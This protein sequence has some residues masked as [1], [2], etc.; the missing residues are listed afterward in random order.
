MMRA[1]TTTPLLLVAVLGCFLALVG[2]TPGLR[3]TTA[4]AR[5][6]YHTGLTDEDLRT[7]NQS[8]FAMMLGEVRAT[9]SDL[10]FLKMTRYAHAGI[11]Y[12]P[13][14]RLDALEEKQQYSGCAAG[15]PTAIRAAADDFRGF[16]GNMEREVKPYRNASKSHQH[17]D[18]AELLPWF[19]LMTLANPH[20]IRGYRVGGM[21]LVKEKE[22]KKALEFMN[23]GVAGNPENP[24]L[25]RLYQTLAQFH[26]RGRWRED[27][28]WGEKWRASTLAAAQTAFELAKLER[29]PLGE[30]GKKVRNLTWTE[31]IEEDFRLAVHTIPLL[32]RDD[33]QLEEALRVA[34]EIQSLI[35]EF[36][37]IDNTIQKIEADLEKVRKGESP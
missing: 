32:L 16:L 19:R 10:M 14:L 18:V 37:P 22:W 28:P 5:A 13:R 29:P 30:I 34:R 15:T 11:G 23:E 12:A 25:F 4:T 17:T 3:H 33:G 9:T 8:A 26:L 7:R 20:Y 27:Y 6:H 1:Q 2:S 21:T 24:E 35:P 36:A 31:D